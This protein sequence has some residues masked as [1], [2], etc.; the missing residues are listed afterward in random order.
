MDEALAPPVGHELSRIGP[1]LGLVLTCWLTCD[2]RPHTGSNARR[3]PSNENYPLALE[4][5]YS[6][7]NSMEPKLSSRFLLAE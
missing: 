4:A 7:D 1:G 5:A 2:A 6:S 3:S